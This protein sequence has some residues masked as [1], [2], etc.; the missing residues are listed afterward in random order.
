MTGESFLG[1][2]E[3][4]NKKIHKKM[5]EAVQRK[6]K[7]AAEIAYEYNKAYEKSKIEKFAENSRTSS[8]NKKLFLTVV[9]IFFRSL[10]LIA[11]ITIL[12]LLLKNNIQEAIV[13]SFNF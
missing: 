10:L 3:F 13:Q 5:N 1:Y 12:C 6:M 11:V 9:M 4:R 8:A 2:R 7:S